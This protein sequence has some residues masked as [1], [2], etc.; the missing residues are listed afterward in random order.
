MAALTAIG[1]AG[2]NM[3]I[4]NAAADK[5]D[6]SGG[7]DTLIGG[8]GND[9]YLVDDINDLANE[10]LGEGVD[11][12]VSTADDFTLSDNIENL[13]LLSAA[14][15]GT[16]NALAN[17]ITGAA[18]G[19]SLNGAGGNDTLIGGAGSDGL[20]G[21][22]GA[23]VMIGGKG[24]DTYFVDTAGDNVV[25]AGPAGEFDQVGSFITYTLGA[26]LEGLF[27]FG[28]GDIDATGNSLDN[29]IEGGIG[30]N[31]LNGLAGNDSIEAG[32]GKDTLVG[33][34]GSDEF[35]FT[36]KNFDGI[37]VI[38]DFNGLPGGDKLDLSDLVGVIAAGSEADFI[39]T[40]V[41]NGSTTI[42]LDIDGA[43]G[44]EGFKDIAVLQGVST[45][46]AGLLA[47][48]SIA[49]VGTAVTPPIDGTGV[50]DSKLGTAVS[51]FIRGFSGNDT[52]TGGAGF[53]TLDGG[54]GADSLIGGSDSDTYIVDSAGDKIDETGGGTDDR[55]LASIGIDLANPAYAGI[56]HATLAGMAALS[57]FGNG[58]ANMLIGNGAANKLDGRGGIDTLAGGAGNDIYFADDIND[59][60]VENPGEG[61][62]TVIS[63]AGND[64]FGYTLGANVENLI[65][66][67][68]AF[69]GIGNGLANKMT[70]DSDS[71]FLNGAGGNDT[72]IGNGGNDELDGGTGADVMIGGK[73]IST[74][75]VDNVGDKVVETGGATDF[76]DTVWSTISYKLGANLEN[77]ILSGGDPIDGTGNSQNNLIEGSGGDN[78]LRG[79]AGNDFLRAGVGEDLLLGGDGNDFLD[80]NEGADTL[81]GGAGS[82]QFRF[83]DQTVS[84]IDVI[85]DFNGLPGGDVINVGAALQGYLP[86]VSDIDDFLQATTAN[87]ST[88]IL[89]DVNGTTGGSNFVDLA[90]IQG[91]GTSI[92][93]LLANGSLLLVST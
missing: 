69:V 60:A 45:D 38:A 68:G 25:E 2:A 75:F 93:G 40:A 73:G 74:Y 55:I 91:V 22:D 89:V 17:K 28:S 84:G 7:V 23:D 43:G 58:G 44:P 72:L 19:S 92:D 52:L 18:S 50:A 39:Q 64:V 79:L 57:A 54:K 81:V 10:N 65:L 67:P 35:S 61:I 32:P 31:V 59:L 70:G 33:G 9:T 80:G 87:G 11:T 24:G 20:N 14:S 82:D 90:V 27:L 83:S 42:R 53:D 85:A 21:S 76:D 41:A 66:A 16:G 49:N 62:D 3:L 36:D 12:V 5:L 51:D 37:D 88:T 86:G 15:E 34:A 48:G 56:E 4:G 1:N 78:V 29:E 77:L 63:T 46:L 13:T 71:S 30:N 6:G 26:N 8:A 47:N